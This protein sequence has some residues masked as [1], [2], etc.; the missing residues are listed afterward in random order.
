MLFK[1][2][3]KFFGKFTDNDIEI[4]YLRIGLSGSRHCGENLCSPLVYLG[5]SET[6]KVRL[7]RKENNK[8]YL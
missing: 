1:K 5:T 3:W 4:L 6:G 2:Q 7:E 8:V